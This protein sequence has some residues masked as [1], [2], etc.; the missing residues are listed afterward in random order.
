M[1]TMIIGRRDG[2]TD[3]QAFDTRATQDDLDAAHKAIHQGN[4]ND[5]DNRADA[6]LVLGDKAGDVGALIDFVKAHPLGVE[7][8]APATDTKPRSA[9]GTIPPTFTSGSRG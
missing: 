2:S 4:R 7:L 5:A 3:V 9:S 6:E 1:Q 8:A